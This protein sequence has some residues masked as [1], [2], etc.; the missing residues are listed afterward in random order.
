MYF[1]M[2]DLKSISK[3]IVAV[4]FVLVSAR[5]AEAQKLSTRSKKAQEL[6][7]KAGNAYMEN[8]YPEAVGLLEQALKKDAGFKE[9]YLLLADIYFSRK[10]YENELKVLTRAVELDST[11]FLSAYYNL[12]VA[13]FYLG[14]TEN[15]IRWMK[16]YKEKTLGQKS[17]LD[18]DR[19]IAS[20]EFAEKA[21]KDPV[22]F[23]PVNLGP[24]INSDYDE[25]WPSITADES[26]MVFTVLVPRDTSKF[27]TQ[28]LPKTSLNFGED[29][30]MSKNING[31]WMPRKPLE[32][33]NTDGNEGAQ[34]LSADGLWMFFTS[35]GKNGENS[36]CDI[37]FSYKTP[38]GWSRPVNPGPPLNTRYWESQPSFSSDGKTLYFV[39][40]R[41]G[42]K[43]KKDIWKATIIGFRK[44]KTP[45]FANVVNLGDNINTSGDEGSPFIHQDDQSLYFSSDGWPGMGNMDIF[46]CRRDNSGKWGKPVNLGYPINTVHDETGLVINAKGTT[47]YFSSDGLPS[48]TKGKDLYS[49]KMP[50]KVRPHPVSYVKGKVF[51]KETHEPLAASFVL[52]NIENDKTVVSSVSDG[53]SGSF[54]VCLPVGHS[55]ALSVQKQG[56]LFYSGN[57]DLEDVKG[58]GDPKRLNV[59]L[60][61][62]RPGEKVILENIF[63][64]TD[65]FRLKKESFAELN[66]LVEL[67]EKNPGLKVEI[68]GHTDNVG[69]KE[70][71][72]TLSEKR[73]ESVYHYLVQKGI[74]KGRLRFKGYGSNEPVSGNDTD[75]GRAQNRRTEIKVLP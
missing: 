17:S 6:Y 14:D 72:L 18:A 22:D 25:Y 54:L 49:F 29:F 64:A 59:Y 19:W 42:G 33:L 75:E 3:I 40:N 56:Y 39:S 71:N 5:T 44:D 48:K 37:Y 70:Y 35:C 2:F 15:T 61:P 28:A 30:F 41:R 62:V 34:C 27:K 21:V 16:K 36:S 9:A 46:V 73:A 67:L 31:E 63:F 26:E 57:F 58:A 10:D 8:K 47:A 13:S 38:Y 55:Y 68:G 65:S 23:E 20:A 45:V 66:T 69:T 43:G 24:D 12:G 11:F 51:D 7:M 53:A 52:K 74:D 4:L 60:S 50:V 32:S 1:L